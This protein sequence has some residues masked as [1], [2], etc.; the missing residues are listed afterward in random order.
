MLDKVNEF[1]RDISRTKYL[2]S[3]GS[4]KFDAIFN[5]FRCLIESKVGVTYAAFSNYAKIKIDSDDDLL[6][7]K[8]LTMYNVAMLI[9][10]FQPAL[11]L[12]FLE[13][14]FYQLAKN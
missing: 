4:E 7:E 6:L 11:M 8:A 2:V 9:K 3:F 13:K 1:I 12:I 10:S 14:R 5:R